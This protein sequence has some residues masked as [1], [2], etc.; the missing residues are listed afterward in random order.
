MEY[1]TELQQINEDFKNE[2]SVDCYTKVA[3]DIND[4]LL[5]VKD[6]KIEETFIIDKLNPDELTYTEKT[7]STIISK[8]EFS[9]LDPSHEIFKLIPSLQYIY[10]MYNKDYIIVPFEWQLDALDKPAIVINQRLYY[11]ILKLVFDIFHDNIEKSDDKAEFKF[12]TNLVFCDILLR[13][14]YKEDV[15]SSIEN[16]LCR[17]IYTAYIKNKLYIKKRL[18]EMKLNEFYFEMCL[19]HISCKD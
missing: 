13:S 10:Q 3:S 15:D 4:L 18:T 6:K 16:M 14:N 8:E 5:L 12:I 2:V 11:K 9:K 17:G 19:S 1:L 7:I